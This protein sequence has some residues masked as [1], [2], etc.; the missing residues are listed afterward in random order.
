MS[1]TRTTAA[2]RASAAKLVYR[3][4]ATGSAL[5]LL[6]RRAAVQGIAVLMYHDV[7]DESLDVDAWAL[8]RKDMFVRQLE[9]LR[10]HYDILSLSEALGAMPE[11]SERT[12]PIAVLT[13][14]DGCTGN[15]EHVL[16]AV[17][18]LCVPITVF[19]ASG[20]IR[21]GEPYWFDRIVNAV[22]TDTRLSVD[23]TGFGLKTYEFNDS[24]GVENWNRIREL[25][26]ALKQVDRDV[27]LAVA[28]AVETAAQATVRRAPAAFRPLD[29]NG[30]AALSRSRWVTIG[31]H[32]DCHRILSRLPLDVARESIV[33][34]RSLLREWTGQDVRYFAYPS[35]TYNPGVVALLAEVGFDAA[36]A[37]GERI[38]RQ[39]DSRLLIPRISVGRYDSFDTFRVQLAGGPRQV[40]PHSA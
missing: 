35:N 18:R 34:S 6:R 2:L 24:R 14:D 25:L 38:W 40:L 23:L 16:P 15:L 7:A 30:V 29:V 20:H 1:F 36:C 4:L 22:Q 32:S 3:T 10:E 31:A 8:V 11:A 39:H 9:Y 26:D 19:V 21:T 27:Q 12:R 28:A 13:F 17:E 33:T 37:G 5:K